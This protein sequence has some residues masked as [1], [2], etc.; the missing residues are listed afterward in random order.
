MK[1]DEEK[2]KCG[3]RADQNVLRC[4]V[5]RILAVILMI[6]AIRLCV[7]EPFLTS[8]IV[9][10]ETGILWIDHVEQRCGGQ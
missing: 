4:Y 8:V 6:L 5:R 7:E 3:K 1:P 9:L 2:R 10:L